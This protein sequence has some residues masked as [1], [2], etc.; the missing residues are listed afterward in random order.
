MERELLK[1]LNIKEEHFLNMLSA[2][3]A[4]RESL[5]LGFVTQILLSSSNSPLERR[6]V[7]RTLSSVSA[8]LPVRDDCLHVIHKSVKDWLTD[9][10]C[11]GKHEFVVDGNEG[12]RILAALCTGELNDLKRKGGD[13]VQFSATEKYALHHGARHILHAVFKREPLKLNELTKSYIVDLEIVYA[14]TCLNSKIAA[15]DLLWLQKQEN[16]TLLSA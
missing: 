4:S 16:S 2:I 13:N 12:H 1:E 7:L 3:I 15:E 5:P 9:I 8:L 10:S 14:K 11:Y 6:K